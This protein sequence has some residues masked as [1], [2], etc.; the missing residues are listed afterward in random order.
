MQR[1]KGPGFQHPTEGYQS[2]KQGLDHND[3]KLQCRDIIERHGQE[4]QPVQASAGK[5]LQEM[6]DMTCLSDI[7]MNLNVRFCGAR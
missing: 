6:N 7:A 3:L 1:Y 2:P 4:R 5:H